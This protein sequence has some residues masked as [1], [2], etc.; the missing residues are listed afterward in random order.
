M[1]KVLKHAAVLVFTLVILLTPVLVCSA[2]QQMIEVDLDG[3]NITVSL[4]GQAIRF[5]DQKPY[6]SDG[7]ALVPVRFIS[8]ALGAQV[9]WNA[10]QVNIE[11]H[12]QS[13]VLKVGSS[14]ATVN[15]S[16]MDLGAPVV[17]SGER[18]MVPLGFVRQVLGSEIK[19]RPIE[20]SEQADNNGAPKTLRVASETTYP[21]FEFVQNGQYVGYD[22]DLIC[23]I[24][25]IEGYDISIIPIGFDQLIPT[26]QNNQTDCAISAMS[27]T[28]PRQQVVDFSEPY[29]TDGVAISVRRDNQTIMGLEDL[30]G[31][32][33]G[34]E[35]GTLGLE[36]CNEIKNKEPKT[37]VKVFDSLGEAL[38]E[39]EQGGADAVISDWALT[40]YYI[41]TKGTT[42][43][44][45]ADTFQPKTN[46]QYGILVKKGNSSLRDIIN[47]GLKKLK[48]DGTMD[49]MQEKWFGD[50]QAI[51]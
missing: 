35:I 25:E 41:N 21:P 48:A 39:L 15:N 18:V 19:W 37:V 13:I 46:E 16:A 10:P 17:I 50:T 33:L 26:L 30:Q 45:L 38:T 24:G 8:E 11:T 43:K 7:R 14:T 27:I 20:G 47:D 1:T 44:T 12:D 4:N 3:T 9:K 40:Q 32:K 2:E 22:M 42:L 6:L 23:A 34:A 29:F 5:P 36:L 31:K 49:Q 28:L 51:Q